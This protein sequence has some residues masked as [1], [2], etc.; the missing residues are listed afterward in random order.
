MSGSFSSCRIHLFIYSFVHVF[1]HSFGEYLFNPKY[2][3][4]IV[5]SDGN[6]LDDKTKSLVEYTFQSGRKT[7]EQ[8]M[9]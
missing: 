4:D 7:S 1:V 2:V 9:T 3:P 6:A 5:L 8:I